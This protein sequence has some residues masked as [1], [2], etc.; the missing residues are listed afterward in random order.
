MND[1]NTFITDF[2]SS[3][4]G[5]TDYLFPYTAFRADNANVTAVQYFSGM[6]MSEN[7]WE[8]AYGKYYK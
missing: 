4:V 7:A 6:K 8:N 1:E 5:G 2:W 3:K